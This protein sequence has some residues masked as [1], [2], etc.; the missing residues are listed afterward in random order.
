MPRIAVVDDSRTIR[1]FVTVLLEDAYDTVEYESGTAA[2]EGMAGTLPDLVLLDISLPDMDG[3]EVLR[4]IRLDPTLAGLPVVALT[5]HDDP[6]IADAFL[7]SGFDAYIAK[8]IVD[9]EAFFAVVARLLAR[10]RDD[11]PQPSRPPPLQ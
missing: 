4:R 8:P 3:P 9:E 1:R 7:A 5:A 10:R 2:L 6:G 11:A